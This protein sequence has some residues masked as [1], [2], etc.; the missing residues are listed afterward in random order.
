MNKL[1]SF[2]EIDENKSKDLSSETGLSKIISDLLIN[3]G[4][5]SLDDA[6]LFFNPS[7]EH[8]HDP[9]LLNDMEKAIKIVF[10]HIEKDNHILIYGDY[11]VDGTTSTSILYLALSK[12][13]ARVTYYIPKREEGYVIPSSSLTKS[14]CL[15][16]C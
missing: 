5:Q 8:F 13:G 7:A 2:P 10:E 14:H 11:D 9:F 15:D 16:R 3:R 1:W 6:K 4:I 12:M